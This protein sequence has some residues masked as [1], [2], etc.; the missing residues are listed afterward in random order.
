MEGQER[1]LSCGRPRLAQ[2]SASSTKGVMF[3][4]EPKFKRPKSNEPMKKTRTNSKRIQIKFKMSKRLST[5]SQI[6]GNHRRPQP[7]PA[8]HGLGRR[9][10]WPGPPWAATWAA[11]GDGLGPRRF[12]SSFRAPIRS[13]RFLVR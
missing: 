6:E 1:N 11:V 8:A 10:L 5:K 13:F 9:G 12:V 3:E 4:D 7:T 2:T